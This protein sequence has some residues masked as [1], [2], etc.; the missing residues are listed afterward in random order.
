MRLLGRRRPDLDDGDLGGRHADDVASLQR[1]LDALG[2]FVAVDRGAVG[3]PEVGD[4]ETT[5]HD[6]ED[7]VAARN[8]G[9]GDDEAR[10]LPT[11]L[12]R[13]G[14]EDQPAHRLVGLA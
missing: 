6:D 9:V 8:A 11:H 13:A 14:L 12:D 7:D 2:Q 5:R 1:P 10:T 4:D 3:A